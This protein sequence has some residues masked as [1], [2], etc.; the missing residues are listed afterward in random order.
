M[1]RGRD[2]TVHLGPRVTDL[3]FDP[4]FAHELVHVILRQKY[5]DAV[6][7]WLEEGLANHLAYPAARRPK[8]DYRWLAARPFPPDVRQLTH[9][10]RERSADAVHAQYVASEALVEMIAKRCD[11]TNL[12]RLSVGKGMEGYL[13]TYCQ[14]KDLNADYRRWVKSHGS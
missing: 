8:L 5:R 2:L 12:L 4:T 10:F 13:E 7:K 6:P 14:I 3:N 1:T 11:L 9:P